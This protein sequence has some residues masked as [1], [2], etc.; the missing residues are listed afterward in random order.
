MTTNKDLEI[1]LERSSYL[2]NADDLLEQILEN[3][4]SIP[5]NRM[6]QEIQNEI[7]LE[8]AF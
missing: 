3:Q 7:G 8:I 6:G 1:Y 2:L 4:Y 5:I